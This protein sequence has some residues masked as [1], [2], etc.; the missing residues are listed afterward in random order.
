MSAP[1][2][3]VPGTFSQAGRATAFEVENLAN[4]LKLDAEDA[5]DDKKPKPKPAPKISN[6]KARLLKFQKGSNSDK[7]AEE[8]KARTP[9]GELARA[10]QGKLLAD[11]EEDIQKVIQD[12]SKNQE[13]PKAEQI[14][15]P[16]NREG[17]DGNYASKF[18][19]MHDIGALN[20]RNEQHPDPVWYQIRH[21][22]VLDRPPAWDFHLRRKNRPLPKPEDLDASPVS[23]M[24]GL[25]LDDKDAIQALTSRQRAQLK[26]AMGLSQEKPKLAGTMSLNSERGP[27]AKVG[28]NH[29]LGHEVSCAE[30]SDLLDQDI[31]GYPKLRYPR[32]NFDAPEGRKPLITADSLGEPGKYDVNL[33]CVKQVPKSGIG[34]GKALPRSVCVSTMGYSAPPA[35]L[36][37]EEKRTRGILPDR[38][39]GKNAVRHRITH[40][41]D[42]DREMARPPLLTGAAQMF[43]DENDPAACE[44][45]LKREM[46]FDA[47]TADIA[48]T[49]RRDIAPKYNKMLGRGRDAVQGNR[50]LSTD[51]GVRGSVGLGFVETTSMMEHSIEQR[52]ARHAR[53]GRENPNQGPQFDYRTVNVHTSATEKL[54]R[55][56]PL[57]SGVGISSKPSPLLRKDHPMLTTPFKRS[58]S[59]PGFDSRSK[60]GGTRVLAN[61]RSSIAIPGWSPEE[62]DD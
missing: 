60:F 3:F 10:I 29:V 47:T 52:E 42:F 11:K 40:V 57:V 13:T 50:A 19:A 54:G 46:S 59:L 1:G 44:A 38:S 28:R 62:I 56:R 49:H 39:M 4:Q 61:S 43:H 55:G 32:W 58:A 21:D 26:E 37:P 41:N 22:S 15:I 7:S 45:V 51:V 5:D 24:T 53:G 12:A 18:T 20:H 17:K 23:F 9:G 36:H 6:L 2:V 14:S 48:V 30:D 16:F 27:L 8:L 35:A 31:K 25:D 34:F 33:D